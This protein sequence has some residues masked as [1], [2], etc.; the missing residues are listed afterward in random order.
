M[1]ANG[2]DLTTMEIANIAALK[3]VITQLNAQVSLDGNILA[4]K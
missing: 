1:T 3:D 4:N 2:E